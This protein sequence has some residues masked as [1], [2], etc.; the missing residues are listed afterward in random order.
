[1]A[2]LRAYMY[3]KFLQSGLL[4][5]FCYLLGCAGQS[6]QIAHSTHETAKILSLAVWDFDNNS[7]AGGDLDYLSKASSEMLLANLAQNP[8]IHLVERVNLRQA[9]EE[10]HL[11]S[12]ELASEESRLKLGRIAGANHM[13]FGSYV[14]MAGMV[15]IDVRVVDVETSLV[16]FSENAITAPQDVAN[17]LQTIAQ[18]MAAKLANS[19]VSGQP[20]ATEMVLWK[21]YESGISL[22]D[23][24]HYEQAI[25]VFT[26]LL[27]SN[28]NFKAAEK[29]LNL[30]L[31][32]QSRQ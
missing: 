32:R 3:R 26:D 7:M 13:A 25:T 20:L 22:M 31:E 24:H 2:A 28:P 19:T 30:V 8:S 18:H 1:M 14:A 12:S 4:L 27:K 5:L 29:Q 9:L 23:L 16:K 6:P 10:Q 11:G 21:R 15:R 17:N